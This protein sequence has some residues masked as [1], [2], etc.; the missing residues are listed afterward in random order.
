MSDT[1]RTVVIELSDDVYRALAQ[2]AEKGGMT[3]AESLINHAF[4]MTLNTLAEEDNPVRWLALYKLWRKYYS[5]RAPDIDV[6]A[7][8]GEI[9]SSPTE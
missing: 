8:F 1:K 5:R 9:G 3:L 6:A 7:F 4:G 2:E